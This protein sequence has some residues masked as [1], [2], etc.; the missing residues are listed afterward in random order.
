MRMTWLKK[1]GKWRRRRLTDPLNEESEE[2]YH[3]P[4]HRVYV[5]VHIGS[6][7]KG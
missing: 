1:V 3:Q 6:A 2:R 5:V 4:S 7:D